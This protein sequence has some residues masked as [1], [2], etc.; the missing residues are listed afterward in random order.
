MHKYM[1]TFGLLSLASLFGICAALS[2]F[3]LALVNTA[4]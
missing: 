4:V 1:K 2:A 3:G